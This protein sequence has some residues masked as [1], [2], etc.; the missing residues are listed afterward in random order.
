MEMENSTV[1]VDD[2]NSPFANSDCNPNTDSNLFSNFSYH[3]SQTLN[4]EQ[5]FR[6]EAQFHKFVAYL[7]LTYK[8]AQSDI[9]VIR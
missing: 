8:E 2:A 6:F 7:L 5:F 4:F 9:L 1:A 3:F